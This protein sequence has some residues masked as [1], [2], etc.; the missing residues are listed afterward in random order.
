MERNRR[1]ATWIGIILGAFS[2]LLLNSALAHAQ[3]NDVAVVTEKFHH[4]YPVAA[5]SRIEVQ[6]INGAVHIT[7][8]DQTRSKST[9]ETGE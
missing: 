1:L 6:D 3:D 5:G 8:S 2:A 9:R 7:P 4:T